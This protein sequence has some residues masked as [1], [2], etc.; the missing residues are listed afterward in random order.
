MG[1][2]PD[3]GASHRHLLDLRRVRQIKPSGH[4]VA[5]DRDRST[6]RPYFWVCVQCGLRPDSQIE[7]C[8][9]C[10][11]RIWGKVM[12]IQTRNPGHKKRP[13]DSGDETTRKDQNSLAGY[14]KLVSELFN[15]IECGSCHSIIYSPKG[16]FDQH[17]LEAETAKHYSG[18]PGCRPELH[19]S[20]SH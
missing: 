8:P 19:H 20:S 11:S 16:S 5:A 3:K 9:N 18:S 6:L 17:L 4:R 7:A 2:E 14:L 15:S 12:R 10:G 1:A 13:P